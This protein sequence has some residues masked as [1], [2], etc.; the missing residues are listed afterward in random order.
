MSH[1][2]Q[3]HIYRKHAVN[4]DTEKRSVMKTTKQ[5][6]FPSLACLKC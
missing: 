5:I 6:E 3:Y 2:K 1:P 4:K